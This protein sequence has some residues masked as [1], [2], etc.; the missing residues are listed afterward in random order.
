MI[1]SFLYTTGSLARV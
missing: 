1:S